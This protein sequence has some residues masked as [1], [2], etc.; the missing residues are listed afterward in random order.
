MF[1]EL[2]VKYDR[3][4]NWKMLG[5]YEHSCQLKKWIIK[6]LKRLEQFYK[7]EK[8]ISTFSW[9]LY[10]NCT[11]VLLNCYALFQMDG[12]T[13]FLVKIME[14]MLV[15]QGF[16]KHGLELKT[17]DYSKFCKQL[18]ILTLIFNWFIFRLTNSF[19]WYLHC[20][21]KLTQ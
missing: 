14:L 16:L 18:R 1:Q 6:I 3:G 7:K 9:L 21:V 15:H 17:W 2:K 11:K 8:Q 19:F 4:F 10:A 13:Y 5:F 20:I 12:R